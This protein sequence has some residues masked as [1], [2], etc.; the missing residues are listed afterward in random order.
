[1][2]NT[3]KEEHIVIALEKCYFTDKIIVPCAYTF[4]DHSELSWNYLNGVYN[5]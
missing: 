4:S 5:T 2:S 3:S 1:M